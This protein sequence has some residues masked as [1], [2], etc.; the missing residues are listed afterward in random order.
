MGSY[1]GAV[2]D[3]LYGGFLHG[4]D[5]A[6]QRN[7]Q[8]FLSTANQ[9][10]KN[11]DTLQSKLS[12]LKDANGNSLPGY[13]DTMK[14]LTDNE[15]AIRQHWHPDKN[16]GMLQKF[17]HMITDRM[18]ITDPSQRTLQA[19]N[20]SLDAMQGDQNRAQALAAAA[21]LSPAQVALQNAHTQGDVQSAQLDQAVANYRKLNPNATS[22]Q[23]AAFKKEVG[24]SLLLGRRW[25]P[26]MD[27]GKWTPMEGTKDGKPFSYMHDAYWNRNTDMSG[28][29]LDDG[30]LEGFVP[31]PKPTKS[32]SP[33]SA[34]QIALRAYAKSH[35]ISDISEL[36]FS[37]VQFVNGVMAQS[38]LFPT[39][40]T[41][42]SMKLGPDNLWYP[43]EETGVKTPGGSKLKDPLGGASSNWMNEASTAAPPQSGAVPTGTQP[44]AG[45]SSASPQELRREAEKRKPTTSTSPN[46]PAATGNLGVRV[47]QPILQ[48]KSPAS[49]DANKKL[50]AAQASYEEVAKAAHSTNPVDSQGIILSWLRGKVNRV[51][52]TEIAAVKNL[53]G[54]FDKF[55]GSLSSVE[56]GVM[57]PKQ[58]SWFAKN[59][60]DNL[61]IARHITSQYRNPIQGAQPGAQP[62]ATDSGGDW[63][64]RAIPH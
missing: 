16:P 21:P 54:I 7:Q 13:D 17:S 52:A 31:T 38:R 43:I 47:G 64:S 32:G 35:N 45:A 40:T 59:A 12:T 53:G 42:H 39:S 44:A 37:A 46:L 61:D 41:S 18:G 55:D 4:Q 62:G 33:G 49:D 8:N 36:P 19:N 2:G 50:N 24:E 1:G 9:L 22:A 28:N 29:E 25:N 56:H 48:G 34:F 30:D 20:K 63:R 27:R 26:L 57:T 58:I 23:E 60:K 6:E 15:T 3:A 14:A 51:T 11:R 10:F 5:L